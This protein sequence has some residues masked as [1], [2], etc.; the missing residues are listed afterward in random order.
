[1]QVDPERRRVVKTDDILDEIGRIT[2]LALA[3]CDPWDRNRANRCAE[4]GRIS[5]ALGFALAAQ[6][7][8]AS[9][10]FEAGQQQWRDE[11]EWAELQEREL[12]DRDELAEVIA[13]GARPP[14]YREREAP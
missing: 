6:E 8:Q 5:A 1:M 2:E 7:R 9:D 12:R 11:Q 13:M 3:P 14:F 10:E 4:I